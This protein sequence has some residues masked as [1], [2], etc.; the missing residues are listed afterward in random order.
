MHRQMGAPIG[1][2]RFK[3]F[4]KQALATDF[5]ERFVQNLIALRRHAQDA[6]GAARIQLLQ[7]GFDKL[8][9]PQSKAT[10]T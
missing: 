5:G 4:H 10:F 7:L 9:L 6:H 8:G 1:E 2:R 3:F